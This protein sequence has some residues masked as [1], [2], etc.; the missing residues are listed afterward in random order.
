MNVIKKKNTADQLLKR[1]SE[2]LFWFHLLGAA[3]LPQSL[4]N[5]HPRCDNVTAALIRTGFTS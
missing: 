1:K 5:K 3:K 2:S 4:C